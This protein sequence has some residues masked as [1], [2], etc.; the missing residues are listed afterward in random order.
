MNYVKNQEIAESL[1]VK[2]PSVTNMLSKLENRGLVTYTKRK[3]VK[4]T[5][6]GKQITSKIVNQPSEYIGTILTIFAELL[7]EELPDHKEE[8][9]K[10][11]TSMLKHNILQHR[12]P[13]LTN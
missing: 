3:G 8:I 13:F 9:G 12:C 6:V 2:A 4:L 7:E 5:A 11:K 1:Q 10:I